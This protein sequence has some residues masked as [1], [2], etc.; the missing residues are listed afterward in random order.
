VG[1]ENVSGQLSLLRVH[2]RGGKFGPA[3]DQIDVE[4][5]AQIAAR[6]TQ[7]YGMKLRTGSDLPANEGMLGLL[8]DGFNHNWVVNIDFDKKPG[9]NNSVLIRVWLT[10]AQFGGG[11]ILSEPPFIT[12][13]RAKSKRTAVKRT[14]GARAARRV[15]SARGRRSTG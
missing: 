7:F 2:R 15:P 6:P 3:N 8:R 11:V 1:I 5:I 12:R 4:V 14:A 9:K 13:S 10:K